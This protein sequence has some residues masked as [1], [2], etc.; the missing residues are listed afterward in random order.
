MLGL[1]EVCS[2]LVYVCISFFSFCGH[3]EFWERPA[4][5]SANLNKISLWIWELGLSELGRTDGHESA[6]LSSGE[7]SCISPASTAAGPCSLIQVCKAT[8]CLWGHA[9]KGKPSS[10]PLSLCHPWVM[11]SVDP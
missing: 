10:L 9:Y 6:S 11:L 5:L 2:V 8:R 3:V 7:I 1:C 4:N